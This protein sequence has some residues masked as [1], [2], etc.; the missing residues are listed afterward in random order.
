MPYPSQVSVL[1][2]PPLNPTLG[3]F[4]MCLGVME[5]FVPEERYRSTI[6][7]IIFVFSKSPFVLANVKLTFA[8]KLHVF[9]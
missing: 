9:F 6:I 2:D 1:F 5:A 3:L 8:I 4:L 7:I